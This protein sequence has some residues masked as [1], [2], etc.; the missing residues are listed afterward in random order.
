MEST[1]PPVLSSDDKLWAILCHLSLFLGVG[2]IVPLIVYLVKKS[3]SAPAAAHA[4]EALNFH[5]SIYLYGIIAGVL[6]VIFIGILLLPL[7]ALL[8]LV[9]SIIAAVKASQGEFYRYPLT[10]RFVK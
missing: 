6:T 7:I 10:I 8:G 3:D 5:I 9:C 1:P 2:V 4:K